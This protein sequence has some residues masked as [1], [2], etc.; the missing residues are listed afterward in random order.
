MKSLILRALVFFVIC[1][2][3]LFMVLKATNNS[4]LVEGCNQAVA[5]LINP[6]VSPVCS[7]RDSGLAMTIHNPLTKETLSYDLKTGGELK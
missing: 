5:A 1:S 7:L 2:G 4:S 6:S 3:I